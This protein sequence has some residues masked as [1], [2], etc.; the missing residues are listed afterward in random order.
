MVFGALIGAPLTA[1][2]WASA[3]AAKPLGTFL[4]DQAR[5]IGYLLMIF[6]LAGALG[7]GKPFHGLR[8]AFYLV[9]LYLVNLVPPVAAMAVGWEGGWA[10][11]TAGAA[12]GAAAGWVFNRWALP[13][14]ENRR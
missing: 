4:E 13:E 11:G 2:L 10:L 9:P 6:A 12:A 5:G 14:T 3:Y 1:Y 8:E 7:R